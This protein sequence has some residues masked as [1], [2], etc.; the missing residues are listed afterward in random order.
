MLPSKRVRKD[1]SL[2]QRY[3]IVQRL[4]RG[5]KQADIA[6]VFGVDRT[7]IS[8]IKKNENVITQTVESG[9]KN[10]NVKRVKSFNFEHVD[11]ELYSWF[12]SQVSGTPGLSGT[13]LMEKARQLAIQ[14]GATQE[15]AA[16]IDMNWINRFKSRRNIVAKGRQRMPS[17]V[18]GNLPPCPLCA[19]QTR[20]SGKSGLRKCLLTGQPTSIH[21]TVC[22][23]PE[24]VYC[25][26]SESLSDVQIDPFIGSNNFCGYGI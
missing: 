20:K 17:A 15:H 13:I 25:C 6:I 24:C 18:P 4:R 3:D 8:K 11:N 26:P 12:C 22:I 21:V 1:L 9:T 19:V 7:T 5:E 23:H 14:S 16:S 10:V 2:H